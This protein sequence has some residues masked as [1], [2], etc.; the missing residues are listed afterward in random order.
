MNFFSSL[1]LDDHKCVVDM[2]I[3]PSLP[4]KR[5]PFL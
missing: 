2:P 4:N 1:V 5:G 3:T